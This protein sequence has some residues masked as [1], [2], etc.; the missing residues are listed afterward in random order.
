MTQP[1][2]AHKINT[3]DLAYARCYAQWN[4]LPFILSQ[5][6]GKKEQRYLGLGFGR[7]SFKQKKK[8][9]DKVTKKNEDFLRHVF[10]VFRIFSHVNS[11]LYEV[12]HKFSTFKNQI[13]DKVTKRQMGI[14]CVT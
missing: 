3:F 10:A 13:P 1:L 6:Y 9:P 5:D 8:Y 12:N 11:G 7:M 14:L 2:Y 4:M